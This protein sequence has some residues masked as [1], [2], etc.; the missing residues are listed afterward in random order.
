MLFHKLQTL[1][2][3]SSDSGWSGIKLGNF[4]FFHNF[5]NSTVIG[6]GGNSFKKYGGGTVNQGAINNI[7]MPCYPTYVGSTPKYV[8]IPILEHVFKSMGSKHHIA[9][10]SV[11]HSFGFAR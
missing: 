1:L 9:C 6:I 7:T 11:H 5:P 10:N 2:C 3:Q 8:V 4:V